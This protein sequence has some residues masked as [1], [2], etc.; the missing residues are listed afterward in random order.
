MQLSYDKRSARARARLIAGAAL[1]CTAVSAG[2][3]VTTAGS[4][5]A[6]TG[7]ETQG[8]TISGGSSVV[9]GLTAS[10]SPATASTPTNTVTAN[11]SVQ[12]Q[13]PVALTV[14]GSSPAT[15]TIGSAAAPGGIP[16]G[17][18]TTVGV[19][20]LATGFTFNASGSSL[21]ASAT[22]LVLKLGGPTTTGTVNAGDKLL[23][24]FSAANPQVTTATSYVFDVATSGSPSA[25]ATP[26]FTI[27][28][29]SSPATA[30]VDSQSVTTGAHFTLSGVTVPSGATS[31]T[32]LT[33]QA[34]TGSSAPSSPCTP[35]SG[36]A[37]G[38]GGVVFSGTVSSYT[39]T[40]TTTSKSLSVT[41]AAP[42]STASGATYNG[43]VLLT[44]GSAFAT[45]DSLSITA[46]ASTPASPESDYLV[47]G[48][49]GASP[50][51]VAAGPL[52]FGNSV[53]DISVSVS[54]PTENASSTYAV[55]FT[56]S[57]SGAMPSGGTIVVRAPKGT[58]FAQVSGALVTQTGTQVA[59]VIPVSAGSPGL[60]VSTTSTTSDTLTIKTTLSI[61]DSQSLTL[62]VFN[63]TNPP[64]G[65]YAGSSGIAVS[66]SA[67]PVPAYNASVYVLAPVVVATQSPAVSVSPNTPGAI[68]T[69]TISPFKAASNLSAAVD[70]LEVSGP[71]GTQ[72]PGSATL[73]DISASSSQVL[74]AKSGQ[75]TNDV[76]YV[77]AASVKAGDVLS[78]SLSNVV[79][80]G[81]TPAGSVDNIMLGADSVNANQATNGGQ[82]LTTD[83]TTTTTAPPTTTTTV[84]KHKANKPVIAALTATAHVGAKNHI[85]GIKLRC[86]SAACTG[87][88]RFVSGKT[89]FGNKRY[90]LGAGQTAVFGVKLDTAALKALAHA[91]RH[92]L[93]ITEITSVGGGATKHRPL[94]LV[95]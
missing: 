28:P 9:A 52:V 88:I 4:A 30:S 6:F 39:V 11:Y 32:S 75:S 94:T 83:V 67:D 71:S 43:G 17:G 68:A 34:C 47:A 1:L 46:N 92:T 31:K 95:G 87:F 69:Y 5:L 56:T 57:S 49:P 16:L 2:V 72:F 14:G 19:A 55:S 35:G 10:V 3:V 84:A 65:S 41:G 23:L 27:A 93:H 37:S 12:F 90:H 7:V 58:S 91:K 48:F 25:Q 15:V 36:T 59:Q 61:A 42:I 51:V 81:G 21:S 85:A 20:D 54:N 73:V 8:Y 18:V 77:L 33:L 63:V 24:T 50:S 78:L 53:S 70:S 13:T 79:N 29:S 86:T 45:G 82:G 66:T 64:A 26:A 74:T 80:P 62:T 22:S 76:V 40:D 38:T 60:S 44:L 89:G